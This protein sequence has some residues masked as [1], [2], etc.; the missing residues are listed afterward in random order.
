MP[1]SNTMSPTKYNILARKSFNL[2]WQGEPLKL[3]IT[4]LISPPPYS[5]WESGRVYVEENIF[6]RREA[7]RQDKTMRRG[8]REE[9]T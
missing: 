5:I 8:A 9:D 4:K 1:A 6:I 7:L 2:K 3:M